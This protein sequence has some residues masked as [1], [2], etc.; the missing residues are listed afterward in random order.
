M[1]YVSRS[2]SLLLLTLLTVFSGCNRSAPTSESRDMGSPRPSAAGSGS[3][4]VSYKSNVRVL[5]QGAGM[6][7]VQGVSSN[8]AALLL[9]ASNPQIQTLKAG[10]ALVIKGLLAKKI[11]VAELQGASLLVLT[12][13]ATLTDVLDHGRIRV[14]A[15]VR[16]GP[17]RSANNPLAPPPFWH[18][19]P[20]VVYAQSAEQSILNNAE[21]KGTSDAY[22]NML[23][24]SKGAIIEGWTTDWSATPSD[25]RLNIQLQ[26]KKNVGGFTALITGDGYLANFD[27]NSDIGIEQSTTE[28]IQAGFK[29]L[30]G[31]MNFKWEVAKDTPGVQTGDDRI[32]LP[33][34]IEVPL[35][36][37]LE[38]F[39]LFLEVSSALIIKLAI[40]GGK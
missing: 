12:Q 29:N 30:N 11:V 17:L 24:G 32:K 40:S 10:D 26:M 33:A 18:L 6:A 36:R 7:A 1:S 8:G 37:F 19:F 15:P 39:P 38:G 5:D 27:F 23:K 22:G 2:L 28:Q 13:Q 20:S 3:A 21:A 31:V 16:F 35:Y 14:A 34:A 9:D 25:G 4:E